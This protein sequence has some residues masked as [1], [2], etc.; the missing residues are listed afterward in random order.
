MAKRERKSKGVQDILRAMMD[1]QATGRADERAAV[2]EWL[3]ARSEEAERRGHDHDSETL[4]RAARLI[5][6]C[7]HREGK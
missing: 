3:K 1:M 7:A 6:K 2:V 4:F 5:E